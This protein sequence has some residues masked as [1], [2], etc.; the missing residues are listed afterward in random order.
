MLLAA[1]F[2]IL[3]G[4]IGSFGASANSEVASAAPAGAVMIGMGVVYAISSLIYIYPALK[5]WK[6]AGAITQLIASGSEQDLVHALDQQR[7]FWKFLGILMIVVLGIYVV[8]IVVAIIAMAFGAAM[9][10]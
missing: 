1:V 7:G 3:G 10:G 6:Y 8:A 5:L 9:L 2:I 4:L